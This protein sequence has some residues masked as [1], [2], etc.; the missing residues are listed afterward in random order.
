MKQTEASHEAVHDQVHV[1]LE[2]AG[3][4]LSSGIEGT[5]SRPP[6]LCIRRVDGT[7]GCSV[8]ACSCNEPAPAKPISTIRAEGCPL[9]S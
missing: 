1:D 6:M 7:D 2:K 9:V 5:N 4:V 8:S 3:D